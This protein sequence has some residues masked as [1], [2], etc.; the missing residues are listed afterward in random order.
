MRKK[1]IGFIILLVALSLFTLG[2]INGEFAIFDA[3][4][5]QMALIP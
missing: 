1:L 5:E 2:I 3:I 4:Y